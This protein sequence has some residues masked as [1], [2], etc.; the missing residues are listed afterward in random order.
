MH[1]DIPTNSLDRVNEEI[2]QLGYVMQRYFVIINS[3]PI[4]K[5]EIPLFGEWSLKDLL[6]HF[7]GWNNLTIQD[8]EKA[9]AGEEIERWISSDEEIN[10]FNDQQ[11]KLRRDLT[12][13]EVYNEFRQSCIDLIELYKSLNEQD[14]KIQFGPENRYS[15][16]TTL[17]NDISHFNVD[18][19]PELVHALNSIDNNY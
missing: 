1:L 13:N 9:I 11:V 8:I 4:E 18:H 2:Y 15:A 6:A 12:W 14:L 7:S 5:R 3:F 10:E 19:L 16:V 17:Q